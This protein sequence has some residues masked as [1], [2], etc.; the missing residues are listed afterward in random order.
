MANTKV[1]E[2][3]FGAT[4]RRQKREWTKISNPTILP[5]TTQARGNRMAIGGGKDHL[6]KFLYSGKNVSKKWRQS[7]QCLREI[8]LGQINLRP[9]CFIR[10]IKS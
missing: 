4:Q 3:I 6:P 10:N 9:N 1:K 2:C 5:D 8:K 7:N